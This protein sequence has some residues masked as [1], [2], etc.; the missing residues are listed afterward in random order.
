MWNVGLRVQA[1]RTRGAYAAVVVL[2][3]IMAQPLYTPTTIHP[4][5]PL[6]T[7]TAIHPNKTP[8]ACVSALSVS[9]DT[10]IGVYRSL[11]TLV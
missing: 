9:F 5:T 3:A 4:Y 10:S 7:P 8:P 1:L 2:H 6:Y 11:L